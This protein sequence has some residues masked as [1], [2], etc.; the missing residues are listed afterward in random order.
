MKFAI[1]D[2]ET[3]GGNAQDSGITEIGVVCIDDGTV[4]SRFQ[5]LIHPQQHIPYHITVLT[6]I[7][8]EMVENAPA[9]E[10]VA[11]ELLLLLQDRVFVAHNVHFDYSFIRQNMLNCGYQ[12]QPRKLCTVRYARKLWPGKRSYSL[13]TL[14]REMDVDNVARHRAMGDADATATL[15]LK[16][17]NQDTKKQHLH[18]LLKTGTGESI[19]PMNVPAEIWVSLPELP[20]VYYFRD[21]AGKVLYVGKAANLRQRVRSHFSNSKKTRKLQEWVR[22][23]YHIDFEVCVTELHALVLEELEIKRLWPEFNLGQ[24]RP[25]PYYALYDYVDK[26]GFRRLSVGKMMKNIAPI[27]L[28]NRM[29]DCFRWGRKLVE[30]FGVNEQLLFAMGDYRGNTELVTVLEHNRKIDEGIRILQQRLPRFLYVERGRGKDRTAQA[31]CYLVEKGNF[32]GMGVFDEDSGLQPADIAETIRREKD[33]AYIR[34]L[35]QKQA[36]AYPQNVVNLPYG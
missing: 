25:E 34:M 1:V 21:A 23:I 27:A 5:T 19:L 13:G 15:F 4:T 33:N 31:V 20:G 6:G 3:T 12:W 18:Q 32:S 22:R 10:E 36:L 24:K 14:C 29:E 26:R 17:L 35:I 7:T 11:G 9:F 16:M 2:I 28:F 30:E 8:N